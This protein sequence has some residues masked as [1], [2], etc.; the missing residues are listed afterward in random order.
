MVAQIERRRA[1]IQTQVVSL[2]SLPC[3]TDSGLPGLKRRKNISADGWP[4]QRGRKR[5]S[6]WMERRMLWGKGGKGE[7]VWSQMLKVLNDR[8]RGMALVLQVLGPW[9]TE[10]TNRILCKSHARS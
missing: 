5:S 2:H 3:C 7:F 1:R 9:W 8:H 10:V 4:I 6:R